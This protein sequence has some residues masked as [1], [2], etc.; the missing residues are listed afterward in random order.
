MNY[1][2]IHLVGI[3]GISM[4]AL[5]EYL[6]DKNIKITGSDRMHSLVTEKLEKLGA[7]ISYS[8]DEKNIT[9]QDLIIRTSAVHDDNP[10]IIKARALGIKILERAE[11]WGEIMTSYK[12]VV[13]I[14]GTHGKTSTTS[15]IS[16]ISVANQNDPTI[17]VGSYLQLID[18]SLRL[19]KQDYFIA[20]SCEYCNSFLSFKPTI[21]VINNIEAD[22][23]D[24][25]K[26][27][28]DIIASFT[29]F[30]NSVPENGHVIYNAD[31]K[32]AVKC[33]KN[34]NKNKLSFG[35]KNTADIHPANIVITNGYYSFDAMFGDEILCHIKLNVPGEHNLYNALASLAVMYVLNLDR[36]ISADA[37]SKFTGSA[38]RFQKKGEYNG[39]II[40]DDYAHH[41][42]EIKTTLNTANQMGF[43][44]V[45]CI[46]QSHT[47]TRTH[48]LLPDFIEAL[49][50][51]DHFVSAEIYSAREVNTVG[52]SGK[53]LS[54]AIDGAVFFETFEEIENYIKKIAKKGDLIITMGAGNVVDIGENI[55]K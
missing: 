34:I 45:I 6:M 21:A 11:A 33:V 16:H 3:G 36:A 53:N 10:E 23:L 17:M 20:E 46:F 2:K 13:C 50:L 39:A 47:Y 1:K 52:I 48:A 22:H 12:N 7:E 30:A 43:D 15:M 42:T 49:K 8:H 55:L 32:N 18:G 35:V 31:D 44:R 14:A 41:P 28:D 29:K 27:L 38:R 26:D 25:F 5:A 37:L 4:S 51:C 24:F 9:D 54:D 19:G 40:V